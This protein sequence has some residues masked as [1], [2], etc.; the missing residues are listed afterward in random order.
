MRKQNEDTFSW[1]GIFNFKP[2]RA[3]IAVLGIL[4]LL[5]VLDAPASAA[6]LYVG[7]GLSSS[8]DG[9]SWATAYASLEDALDDAE[10]GDDIW[11]QEGIYPLETYLSIYGINNV[12]IYGGFIGTETALSQRDFAAHATILDGSPL[13]YASDLVTIESFNT[14]G[15]V[16]DGLTIANYSSTGS[17]MRIP[18]GNPVLRNCK[19]LNNTTSSGEGTGSTSGYYGGAAMN[20]S[21]GTPVIVN[22]VFAH[23]TAPHGYG[24]AVNMHIASA[25]ADFINCTFTRNS[26]IGGGAMSI[27]SSSSTNHE[28]YNCLF[29]GNTVTTS[30]PDIIANCGYTASYNFYATS[31]DPLLVDPDNGN[32][33]LSPGSPCI[34]Q[35]TGSVTLANVDMDGDSRVI[36]GDGNGSLVVDIGADE[37]DPTQ[38]YFADLYVDVTKSDDSGDGTSWATAKATIQGAIDAA[39]AGNEIWVRTGTYAPVSIDVAVSL[40]GGFVGTEIQRTG[41]NPATCLTIIDGQDSGR[42]V[43]VTAAAVIDGFT[44]TN[45][46]SSNGGGMLISNS[47]ATIANCKISGNVSPD[48]AGGVSFSSAATMENCEITNNQANTGGGIYNGYVSSTINSCLIEGNRSN[49][50]SGGGIFNDGGF[51]PRI[52]NCTIRD[53]YASTNGGGIFNDEKNDAVISGCTIVLNTAT[54]RGGGLYSGQGDS[55]NT[56]YAEPEITNNVIA[57]NWASWG[58]GLYCAAYSRPEIINCTIAGNTAATEGAGVYVVDASSSTR[59]MDSILYGNVLDAGGHSDIHFTGANEA[60]LILLYNNFSVL[61]DSWHNSGA[62][63]RTGNISVN[64][65]FSDYDGPDNDPT[66]GG[67]SDYHLI[68]SAGVVDKGVRSYTVASQGVTLVAPDH[69]LENNTRP[70]GGGV[71]L[72]AYE[73]SLTAPIT[74]YDLTASVPDG[75]GTVSPTFGTYDEGITVTLTATPFTGYQVAAWSGTSDDSS[76]ASTNTVIMN[77]DKIV[78]VTFHS[79]PCPDPNDTDSDDDGIPDDVE[80]ANQNG[81]VDADETNPCLADTDNDGIQDGTESGLTVADADTDPAVFVPD[82]DPATTTNPLLADTDGDG[83]SDGDE[84]LNHNGRVDENEGDPNVKEAKAMPWLPLL[85]LND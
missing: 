4:T 62:P 6:T 79:I 51:A 38:Q 78:T 33:H 80:D 46:N 2:S 41:R 84:D 1:T 68:D 21:G 3:F 40:Y 63:L 30:Q 22:C 47:G 13:M 36:D 64:A 54:G 9:T 58:G 76:T 44:I 39:A 77:S 57:N 26:A 66:A 11:V 42:C 61:D 49:S 5:L 23:N 15:I 75:N 53:N 31:G 83:I 29:W 73:S 74:Q 55:S 37:F 18:G 19:F 24:G 60:S 14:S 70:Q 59:I 28:I 34:D 65:G 48:Y 81:I 45:G 32:Y 12:S 67:D 52:T 7:A 82:A 43:H 17:A 69:D 71:D 72:G 56:N 8:G 16:I 27:Y 10:D 20:V 50:G 25:A 85:L 35:G